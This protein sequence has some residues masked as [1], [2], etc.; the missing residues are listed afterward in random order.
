[1]VTEVQSIM[2]FLE[3]QLQ[4][5]LNENVNQRAVRERVS[6]SFNYMTN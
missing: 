3:T 4:A 1:M 6:I 2:A 5:E